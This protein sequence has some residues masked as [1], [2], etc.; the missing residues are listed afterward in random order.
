MTP[1]RPS[2]VRACADGVDL[3]L[4][5]LRGERMAALGWEAARLP[6]SML[7][8]MIRDTLKRSGGGLVVHDDEALLARKPEEPIATG[9]TAKPSPKRVPQ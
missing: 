6:P 2:L 9:S 5:D 1:F 4:L 3:C 8:D 7:D